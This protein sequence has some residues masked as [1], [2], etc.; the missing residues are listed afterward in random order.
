MCH[1]TSEGWEVSCAVN[2]KKKKKKHWHLISVC[3]DVFDYILK[4]CIDLLQ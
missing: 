4:G 1:L 3:N 2:L